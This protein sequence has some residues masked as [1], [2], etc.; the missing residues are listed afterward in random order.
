M[1]PGTYTF[2]NATGAKGTMQFPGKPDAEI[3]RLRTLAPGAPKV[4]Y[5]TVKVDSRQ[6]TEAVNI[7]CS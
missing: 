6:G 7:A 4:T 5:L 3:E 2:E 1:K